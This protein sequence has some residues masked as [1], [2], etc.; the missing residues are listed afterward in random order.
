[1]VIIF[2]LFFS[3]CSVLVNNLMFKKEIVITVI[4]AKRT[5]Q[6]NKNVW[7]LQPKDILSV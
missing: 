2:A 7:T 4:E 3:Y 5:E 6:N 1:M